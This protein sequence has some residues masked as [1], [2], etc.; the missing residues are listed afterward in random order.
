MARSKP[1]IIDCDVH[2]YPKSKD[3]IKAYLEQPWKDRYNGSGRGF[4]GNPVHG[5]RLDSSPPGGG[6]GGSDPD[7]LR[8]QHIDKYGIDH[9]ILM[10]RA[11][12]NLLP[13]PDFGTAVAAAYNEWLAATWLGE[14]NRDGVFKGSITIAHQDP[15]AAAAEIDRWAGH[16]HFVQVMTDSGAR[17]PFGQRQYYPIYAACER[18]GLPFAIHPGTDGMGINVQPTPGYPTHYIEWHTCLSLSFQAHLVSLLTEGVFERFPGL[19]IVLVEGGVAWLPALMWRLDAEY[20]ALRFEVPW[21]KKRP[22]EYLRDHVRITSQPLERPDQ[23]KF[24]LHTLE[25]M[26]AEHILMFS[27]DYPHWDFDSPQFAFPKLPE[28][29]HR[30]IFSGNARELYGL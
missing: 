24:L 2:P 20:K 3:E 14:Y 21:L 10:P 30:R 25:A 18:H 22:S 4:Y 12:C 17:A 15:S 28:E 8:E 1:G 26:D 27:S 9:C 5:E 16:P 11:F 23:D 19:K 6:P 7:F 29:L 13:D